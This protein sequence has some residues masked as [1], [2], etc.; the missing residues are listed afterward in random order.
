[1]NKIRKAMFLYVS[2]FIMLLA[3]ACSNQNNSMSETTDSTTTAEVSLQE[4]KE[5]ASAN[6]ENFP[7]DL[8]PL[9]SGKITVISTEIEGVKGEQG[10]SAFAKVETDLDAEVIANYYSD[11]LGGMDNFIIKAGQ[12]MNSWIVSC[13]SEGLSLT[14]DVSKKDVTVVLLTVEAE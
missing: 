2:A 11:K 12:D 9:P 7:D 14:V 13:T 6:E 4:S 5:N 3:T 1:M 10:Y 8:L